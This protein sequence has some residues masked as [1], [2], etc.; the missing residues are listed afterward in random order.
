[1]F[2]YGPLT[3]PTHAELPA[4]NQTG[5][6]R[7]CGLAV[8]S[9][10]NR[11]VADFSDEEVSVYS[12]SGTPLTSFPTTNESGPFA[13]AVDSEGNVYVNGRELDVVKYEPSEFPP[14]GSTTYA[15]AGVL[16]PEESNGVAVDPAT[17]DVYVPLPD[18]IA[19]YH[20]NGEATSTFGEGIPGFHFFASLA[21]RGSN[22]K[23]YA[24]DKSEKKAYVLNADGKKLLAELD[25]SNTKAGSFENGSRGIALDQSNGHFYLADIGSTHKV[26]DEF[27]SG[28]EL[29]SEIPTPS[30]L[31]D[32]D[33]SAVA[34][35][36]SEGENAGDVFFSAGHSPSNVLAYG[37]LTYAPFF[38]LKVLKAGAGEGT[39]TSA[40][41]GVN[42]GSTCAVD[43]QEGTEVT[44][45]ATPQ[46]GSLFNSWK[47]C[48]TIVANEC[49]VTISAARSVTANFST[50]PAIES[51]SVRPRDT[52]AL[53]KAT[54][55]PNGE[56]TSY[57]FEF[58]SEAAYQANGES[59][60]GPEEPIKRPASPE[61]IGD[62]D[63]GV[64][65]SAEVTGLTPH[66]PY[67]FRVVASN[68]I[69]VQSRQSDRLH[70]LS[71]TRRL[72]L[73]SRQRRLPPG[74][75]LCLSS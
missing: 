26:I 44:L 34:V 51:Q 73:L 4:L 66:T 35:D 8:D 67:R 32:P 17:D 39:V 64:E 31:S 22:G 56:E 9:A 14:T 30:G 63:D 74:S 28:G 15:P 43:F 68:A 5:F 45:T 70:H 20:P 13:L 40:P 12:P 59:F 57:Q 25:G 23:I 21:V 62:G 33:P 55:N 60:S 42:C 1:M 16:V 46:P 49:K 18:L 3:I 27:D 41:A 54:I 50:K 69:D 2:A 10:G 29:V 72:R 75:A 58:L 71:A 52:S 47:G 53:L 38:T 24:Y 65:V 6:E 19:S 11:Y 61:S 37:P 36:N 48:D 7:A